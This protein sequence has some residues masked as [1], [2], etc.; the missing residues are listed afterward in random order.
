M[1]V[2]YIAASVVFLLFFALSIIRTMHMFQLNS[3]KT[4]THLRWLSNNLRSLLPGLMSAAVVA[5]LLAGNVNPM[6]APLLLFLMYGVL[7]IIQLPRK[8]KKPL[9][10]TK[11]VVRMLITIGV[12]LLLCVVSVILWPNVGF[13]LLMV[14]I[15]SAL[16]PFMVLLA[17]FINKPIERAVNQYYIDDA[18]RLL[19]SC[20]EL[21]TI[22]VTGSYGKT[23]VKY[24]VHTLLQAEFDV[25]R[26]PESYN[27][28][29]GVVKTVRSMLRATH[30]IFVCEMGARHVGDI[31]ELC[32]I[33][34]PKM[35]I[36]TSVGPQ[37]L[38]TFHSIENVA[39]TKFELV[40]ALPEDG[41]AFL[42]MEDA[43]IRSYMDRVKCKVVGYGLS[44]SCDYYA[45]DISASA[46]GTTFTVHTPQGEVETFTTQMVGAHNVINIVGAI[47]VCCQLGIALSKLKMQIHKLEG[48][49]HRL[50]LIRRNGITIIDDA[51]NSN[52]TGSKAAI[53]ALTLFDGCKILVTPGMVELGEKQDELN[54]AFGAYAAAVCDYVMLVG[55]KQTQSI[56]EG[57]VSAG[58]PEDKIF[59]ADVLQEALSKAYEADAAGKEKI[60]LLENDLPDNF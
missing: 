7:C 21:L 42:N 10:Y 15:L 27:T 54:K 3:Y 20:P 25:L 52:P 53:D 56:Y 2:Y 34:K 40:D 46:K 32:E 8:A 1:I 9:V 31:Q 5:G 45:T 51:Y 55:K 6:V 41:I 44:D 14:T 50:Q 29:M 23:S 48:V 30:Q 13:Y 19:E 28:P 59:V 11:R 60:I 57:L 38:E 47:A 36:I 4:P 16:S 39:K 22:G 58:Y 17:N 26:T 12:L 24:I 35:G 18:K 33:A 49:P 43:N 37:H